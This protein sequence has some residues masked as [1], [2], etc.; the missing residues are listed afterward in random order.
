MLPLETSGSTA[1]IPEHPN[2]DDIEENYLKH[3]FMKMIEALREE[4]KN[5]LK[6]MDEKTSKKL[7]EISWSLKEVKKIKKTN[8]ADEGTVKALKIEIEAIKKTHTEGI[9]KMENLSKWTGTTDVGIA[10]RM[11]RMEE[12]L[13]GIEGMREV[14]SSAI[15]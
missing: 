14:N 15:S 10:Y 8:Q 6:E 4:M 9:L 3:N 13:S 12:R 7:E 11:Q 5:S 2:A 1:T